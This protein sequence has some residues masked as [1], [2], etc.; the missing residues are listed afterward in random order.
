[1]FYFTKIFYFVFGLFTIAG[2]LMGYLKAG[3]LASLIAGGVSGVLLLVAGFIFPACFNLGLLLGLVVSVSLAGY[4]LPKY[5][6]KRAIFP[7]G[8]MALLSMASIVITL[9]AWYRR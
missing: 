8:F 1:M 4:F 5:F 6:E 9:F 2:G 3:S 7:S